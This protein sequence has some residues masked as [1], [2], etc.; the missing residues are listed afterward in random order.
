MSADFFDY[1]EIYISIIADMLEREIQREFYDERPPIIKTEHLYVI[2]QEIYNEGKSVC[3]NYNEWELTRGETLDS[4]A[5]TYITD[6]YI[7]ES[8]TD[9]N[10]RLTKRYEDH[11]TTKEIGY[12]TRE[13]YKDGAFYHNY[14]EDTL[15]VLKTALR[16]IQEAYVYAR[17]VN[18]LLSDDIGEG[19]LKERIQNGLDKLN[20]DEKGEDL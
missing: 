6:G 9:K 19:S 14:S 7:V 20:E 4:W 11:I 17:N 10:I 18:L 2:T 5:D 8:K 1:N 3:R 12:F 16:K 15:N 13:E